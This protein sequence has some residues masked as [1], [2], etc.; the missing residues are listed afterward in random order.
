MSLN[1]VMAIRDGCLAT[2]ACVD[3]PRRRASP[4]GVIHRCRRAPPSTARLRS[5]PAARSCPTWCHRRDRTQPPRHII[6]PGDTYVFGQMRTV[7]DRAL[8]APGDVACVPA[9]GTNQNGYAEPAHCLRSMARVAGRIPNL[10]NSVR[11]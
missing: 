3:P 7:T 6:F 10:P 1:N 11:L 4:A 2:D 9:P 8:F 5:R